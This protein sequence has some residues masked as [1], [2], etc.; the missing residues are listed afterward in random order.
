M[1]KSALDLAYQQLSD[2]ARRLYRLSALQTG[3]DLTVPPAAALAGIDRADAGD[4]L[5]ILADA[6]FLD[7]Q[8]TGRWSL[9]DRVRE[10][11][12]AMADR[13]DTPQDREA[14]CVRLEEY[15]LS[16]AANAQCAVIPHRPYLGRYFQT[17]HPRALPFPDRATA[18]SWLQHE[19]LNIAAAQNNAYDHGRNE[20]VW[21]IAEALWGL[22]VHRRLY[23]NWFDAY[24]L[25]VIAARGCGNPVAEARMLEGLGAACNAIKDYRS[26]HRYLGDALTLE[27]AAEHDVGEATAL[28]GLGVTCL[29][30]DE[31]YKALGYFT[32]ALEIH[33]QIG[34]ERGVAVMHRYIGEAHAADGRHD[35]AIAAFTTA[36]A[37]FTDEAER[38]LQARTL[39]GLGYAYLAA[40]RLA[41]ADA[42][43]EQA[44]AAA[45]QA[46]AP[47]AAATAHTG[48][49]DVAH[50]ADDPGR[51]ARHLRRA[52]GIYTSL[53][54]PEAAATAAR[55]QGTS[56]APE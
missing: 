34:H 39:T 28:E 45:Y 4:L 5:D 47:Y 51:D 12:R 38:Y 31:P 10:H 52:L 33:E 15:Y 36:L 17:P 29:G 2:P 16:T 49:A 27:R 21:E 30:R 24:H 37:G 41:D 19:H 32:L 22:F 26:A 42:T 3:P 8:V 18:L 55:L 43:L 9:P 13:H 44:L 20:T 7:E 14:A 11:A 40:G 48:L 56:T 25:G 6:G 23:S 54:V 35:S 53:R 50:E 1:T 46:D